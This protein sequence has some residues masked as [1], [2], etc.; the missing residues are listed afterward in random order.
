MVTEKASHNPDKSSDIV[1][2]YIKDNLHLKRSTWPLVNE[3][4]NLVGGQTRIAAW[5]M[6]TLISAPNMISG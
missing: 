3:G 2:V 4:I 1:R 6:Q 5:H